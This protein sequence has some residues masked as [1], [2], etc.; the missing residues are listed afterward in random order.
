[1]NIPKIKKYA[2]NLIDHE[3]SL[4]ILEFILNLIE[5]VKPV[6]C[7]PQYVYFLIRTRQIPNLTAFTS[8]M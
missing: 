8:K 5:K 4:K 6:F 2:L 7:F 1:M 3:I